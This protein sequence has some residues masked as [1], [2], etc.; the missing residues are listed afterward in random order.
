MNKKDEFLMKL[1]YETPATAI[2]ELLT[3]V[4]NHPNIDFR[5]KG[6]DRD[7]VDEWAVWGTFTWDE[8]LYSLPSNR[9]SEKYFSDLMHS[10]TGVY[11]R[12]ADHQD[13]NEIYYEFGTIAEFDREMSM[14]WW[15]EEL[16][17]LLHVADMKEEMEDILSEKLLEKNNV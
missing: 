5:G 11:P 13:H 10:I 9:N 3:K 8:E 14:Q 15:V 6:T 2:N 1:K 12:F 17:E 7:D 4:D 16:E